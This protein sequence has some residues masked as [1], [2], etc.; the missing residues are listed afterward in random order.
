LEDLVK[1][2]EQIDKDANAYNIAEAR[3]MRENLEAWRQDSLSQIT[4]GEEEQTTS[5]LQ[6]ICSWLKKNESDQLLIFDKIS[7]QGS[8]H[9]GTCS[10]VTKHPTFSSWLRSESAGSFGTPEPSTDRHGNASESAREAR[11]DED[12]IRIGSLV[13]GLPIAEVPGLY[14][15][16]SPRFPFSRTKDTHGSNLPRDPM[17][18][19]AVPP[20]PFTTISLSE[21]FVI[22]IGNTSRHNRQLL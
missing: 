8:K 1:H 22:G 11:D 12:S 13:N 15:T 2:E 16:D 17:S 6:A 21:M 7:T 19:P 5:Q 14:F 4:R 3:S 18:G 10:W 9:P 20:D